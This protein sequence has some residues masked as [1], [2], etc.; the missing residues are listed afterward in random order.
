VAQNGFPQLDDH[1]PG[2]GLSLKSDSLDQFYIF[3]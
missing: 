3:E 2:I 1:K